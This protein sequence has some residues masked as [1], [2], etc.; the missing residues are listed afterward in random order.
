MNYYEELGLRPDAAPEEI[1]QAYKMLARLLHPD[2]QPD[3]RL[4]A[5]AE[6]QMRRLNEIQAILTDTLKRR[7]YDESLSHS[8]AVL[9]A[10]DWAPPPLP[11]APAYWYRFLY[12]GLRH[13]FW[14]LIGVVVVGVGLWCTQQGAPEA[15]QV[16]PMQSAAAPDAPSVAS[17]VLAHSTVNR[18]EPLSSRRL[19][20]PPRRRR[21]NWRARTPGR[22]RFATSLQP[23]RI[24]RS[25]RAF[26]WSI[27]LRRRT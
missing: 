20:V 19:R 12:F 22:P 17:H 14:I 5:M 11:V 23:C 9:P 18:R 2:A 1:R 24:R 15:V 16:V 25:P 7:Q 4:K 8:P 27:N 13:W 3:A 10:P 21:G 6:C 26:P